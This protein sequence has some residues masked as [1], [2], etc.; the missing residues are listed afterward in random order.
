[1][2]PVD[3]FIDNVG[4]IYMAESQASSSQT[5]HMDTHWWF[6]NQLQEEGL[7]KIQFVRSEANVSDIG[8]KNVTGECLENHLPSFALNKQEVGA[9]VADT[10]GSLAMVGIDLISVAIDSS[11][12]EGVDEYLPYDG[13]TVTPTTV[14][15]DSVN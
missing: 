10:N 13:Q 6:V 1:M 5:R 11:D 2:L 4:A 9:I 8:T 7:I 15:L 3:V 12:R 14:G